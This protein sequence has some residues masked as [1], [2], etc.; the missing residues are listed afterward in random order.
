[1][2]RD[3]I[4]IYI[5]TLAVAAWVIIWLGVVPPMISAKSYFYMS[6]GVLIVL[7]SAPL[8]ILHCVEIYKLSVSILNHLR[9]NN[10]EKEGT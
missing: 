1:M 8:V 2:P 9:K 3:A 6:A 4:G 10:Q 7:I 5:R